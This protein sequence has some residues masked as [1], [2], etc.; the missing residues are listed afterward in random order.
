MAACPRSQREGSARGWGLWAI[1][2]ATVGGPTSVFVNLVDEGIDVA[3]G[4]GNVLQGRVGG[5]EPQALRRFGFKVCPQVSPMFFWRCASGGSAAGVFEYSTIRCFRRSK[6]PWP[7]IGASAR[8]RSSYWPWAFCASASNA[9]SGQLADRGW[10]RMQW[11]PN[12]RR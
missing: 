2:A 3:L 5:L 9:R 7:R 6:P 8:M 10:L 12:R 11:R 4:V 1:P